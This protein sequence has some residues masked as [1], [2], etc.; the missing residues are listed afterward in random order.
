MSTFEV[1]GPDGR[2]VTLEGDTPPSE[3][4]LDQIFSSVKDTPSFDLTGNTAQPAID[5]SQL[6]P[7][8]TDQQKKP[9]TDANLFGLPD[10]WE[11]AIFPKY[12]V[13]A[14]GERQEGM[15]GVR[16]AIGQ[17]GEG[18]TAGFRSLGA[19]GTGLQAKMAGK[20]NQTAINEA[21]T[22]LGK[23]KSDRKGVG[24]FVENTIEDVAMLPS[25]MVG[26]PLITA[27]KSALAKAGST[28]LFGALEGATS[29]GVHQAQNYAETGNVNLGEAAVEV[30][31]SGAMGGLFPLLGGAAKKGTSYIKNVISNYTKIPIEYIERAAKKGELEKI[32][33]A[34]TKAKGDPEKLS[35]D[36]LEMVGAVRLRA[37]NELKMVE[38]GLESQVNA[39]Q[40]KATQTMK[41]SVLNERTAGSIMDAGDIVG[42]D[43]GARIQDAAEQSKG[44]V[45]Q[46]FGKWQ[47]KIMKDY[48]VGDAPLKTAGDTHPLVSKI[49]EVYAD[50]G[51]NPKVGHTGNEKIGS[52]AVDQKV[53]GAIERIE[54]KVFNA[55]TIGDA[56][57]QK[58]AIGSMVSSWDEGT[59]ELFKKGSAGDLVLKRIYEKMDAEIESQIE[60][61]GNSKLS[62]L[63]KANNAVYKVGR[64][65]LEQV[66]KGLGMAKPGNVDNYYTKIKNIGVS[67]LKD[68]KAAISTNK[69]VKPIWEELQNGFYDSLILKSMKDGDI[70]P[71]L[72]KQ[73]YDAVDKNIRDLM[74]SPKQKMNIEYAFKSAGEELEKSLSK[75]S[76][77]AE[78]ATKIIKGKYGIA[79]KTSE[80]GESLIGQNKTKD[81]QSKRAI[82]AINNIGADAADKQIALKQ[83]VF[84]E[85]LLGVPEKDKVSKLISDAYAGKK[86]G[87]NAKGELP[88][89]TPIGTGA[90]LAGGFLGVQIA[91]KA[92][93]LEKK[94]NIPGIGMVGGLAGFALGAYSQSPAGAVA[95]VKLI[96]NITSPGVKTALKTGGKVVNNKLTRQA[97]R[98]GALSGMEEE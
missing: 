36:V 58:R 35:D 88:K 42:S 54:E 12:G 37:E 52:L 5:Q 48:G 25:L 55:N 84:V 9:I 21:L 16:Q 62:R 13:Q 59:K 68:I 23:T 98:Y 86:L 22:D 60:Q 78:N 73:A 79:E 6:S 19:I 3:Q 87:M 70:K 10:K 61:F 34:F 75:S 67:G 72:F 41:N 81:V 90:A 74:L 29:A 40:N 15:A 66:Q 7:T 77:D 71:E 93:E 63:W 31:A 44:A 20:D 76:L 38:S 85:E 18:L 96:N 32:A 53:T 50:I 80:I 91:S 43:V 57:N 51:Y 30:G 82:T 46:K 95:M 94:L 97:V 14:K 28:A 8:V 45:S 17:A 24:G 27:G 26:G 11:K 89:Y 64:D 39:A 56:I 49:N 83:L 2:V 47:D 33:D 69:N 92:D 4:E 1:T 65:A